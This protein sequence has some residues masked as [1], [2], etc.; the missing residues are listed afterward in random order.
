[1]TEQPGASGPIALW[2]KESTE[3][4]ALDG[5][6]A[7]TLTAYLPDTAAPSGAIVICPGGGY[8]RRAEHEGAP[9]ARWLTS[10]GIAAFVL[11]YR[12]APH[13]HPAP[14][15]DALRAIQLVRSHAARWNIPPDRVGILGFSAGGHLAATAATSPNR[16][17]ADPDDPIEGESPRP[18][19]LVLGYPVISFGPFTHAGSMNNLL[20]ADPTTEL[21]AFLSAERRVTSETPPAF[22]WH[23]ANDPG[24]SVEHSL[25]FASALHQHGVPF[26]L[27]VYPEGAHGLGLGKDDPEIRTWADHCADFLARYDFRRV[28]STAN[29]VGDALP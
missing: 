22:L 29:P 17:A 10:L 25:A 18:D 20:G 16:G 19:V 24:V 12:V 1:M 21:R 7:P 5:A 6:E 4:A 15:N 11:D 14:L 3:V 9:V 2:S 27:H 28:E 26:A 13:R 8:Q 23:T